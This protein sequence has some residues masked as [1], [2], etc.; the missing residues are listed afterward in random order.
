LFFEFSINEKV[1]MEVAASSAASGLKSFTFMKHVGL[2][3]ASDS[4]LTAV[5]TGTPGGMVVLSADDPSMFSSQNEQDNRHYARLANCPVLEPSNPQE[6]K[7][8]MKYGYE[9]SE[10][11][12]IPVILR[13]T[14]R[15]SHMRGVVEFDDV[16]ADVFDDV[17]IINT[18]NDDFDDSN[19]GKEF[20]WKKG[21][22]K[23]NPKQFVPVP[24]NSM[25]MH[26]KL[27]E[28]M[29]TIEELSNNSDLNI[30][31]NF[32]SFN[33]QYSHE[34]KSEDVKYKN[35]RSE[36]VKY[37]NVRS[38]DVKFKSKYG[39]ISSGSAFN[40][41]YDVVLDD[42]LL[43]IDFKI[44][45]LGF[46]YPFPKDLVLDFIEGLDGIFV[47]EEVDPIMEKEILATIGEVGIDIPVFGKLDGTFPLIHE[48]NSDIVRDSINKI[49]NLS[50]NDIKNDLNI[51]KRLRNIK[52]NLPQRSPT[53]CSGC[54]HRATYFGVRRAAEDLN[55]SN[56][57]L[58]FS[59]DIGCYTLG[60]SPPY[61]TTDYLLSMGS[62]IGDACG[63]SV[64]T[65][66]YIV[67]F[68]GDST[69]F[70]GGIPPLING[71]HN[72]HRFVV[73][74]LDNRTTAMTGGQPNPGI[75]IDGMGDLAP[76]IS[77][78]EI[79]KAS[80]CEF[81]ETI[82]PMNLNK[83]IDTY[84]RALE[85]DGV[86]VIIAKYPCTLIKGLKRKRPMSIKENRCNNCKKCINTLA[87]PAISFI[88]DK[89]EIDDFLCKGCTVCVQMCDQKAIGVKKAI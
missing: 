47:I 77:I 71:V 65:N 4:F 7:D 73:T 66:Q 78:E 41:A 86:S 56:E 17:G 5:Y 13:T 20:H 36:D 18:K 74:V 82:N 26:E 50:I 49:V 89:V 24:E 34:I 14:T 19:F 75:P 42:D 60:V 83:T 88:D 80:G 37:K 52:D 44:L 8:M 69:F 39:I 10:K 68:I 58:I 84:K 64:A 54:S 29:E 35:A 45:K 51:N 15:I 85:Y 40:Y 6:V 59:S 3:V 9:L 61:E 22:F 43:D 87:C 57:N 16:S 79:A 53:L 25:L 33:N 30:I 28:K 31:F 38:E 55:I 62:S 72:K 48:F 63:F 81:V 1:A 11:F 67:S 12:S 27:V 23:K 46:T 70:H 76:E 2:N 32:D 21:F